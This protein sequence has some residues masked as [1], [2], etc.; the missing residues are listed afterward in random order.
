MKK[1]YIYILP[2]E[3][4]KFSIISKDKN[5][6]HIN[7]K[8]GFNSVY[9]KNISHGVLLVLKIIKK[10]K[11]VIDLPSIYSLDIKFINPIFFNDRIIVKFITYKNRIKFI[12]FQNNKK[13]SILEIFY[14]YASGFY[15]YFKR[16]KYFIS[17]IKQNKFYSFEN[18][19]LEIQKVLCSISYYVGMIYPG[20]NGILN[21]IKIN[22]TNISKN[23][24][25]N[26]KI[27]TKK[28]D[29]RYNYYV[30]ELIYKDFLVNFFSSSRP[31]FK[32]EIYK[33]NKKT[34]NIIQKIKND[35]LIISGSSALGESF[36]NLVSDNQKLKIISTFSN[37]K[38]KKNNY[39]NIIFKKIS[40]PKDLKKLK[41]IISKLKNPYVFY[42]TSP[43]IDF[44]DK[45]PIKEQKI[46]KL[47]YIDIPIYLLNSCQSKINKFIYPSTT[48]INYNKNSFYSKIKKKAEQELKN[49]SNVFVYRFG[50]LYSKNTI[51]FQNSNVNNLQKFFNQNTKLLKLI[52]NE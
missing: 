32:I 3:A 22:K 7:K 33:N 37:Q 49:F 43:I 27:R 51:T 42:F 15:Q 16:E 45:L 17:K 41:N 18:E 8:T 9:R 24:S 47:I 44:N 19:L 40:F 35:I 6:I 5:P 20:T 38:P 26:L 52:F 12:A 14:N 11:D 1:L 23:K 34:K 13:I 30:N 36:L 29:K 4:K 21:S 48:N 50:K 25:S 31:E 46:Y 28:I 39:I 2:K 10:F